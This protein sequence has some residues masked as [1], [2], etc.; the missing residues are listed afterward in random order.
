VNALQRIHGA[1][2]TGGVLVDT[3][4]VSARPPVQTSAGRVGSLDMSEWLE[5]VHA[6]DN[7]V[8]HSIEDGLWVHDDERR[9]VVGDTFESGTELVETVKGWQGTR[10]SDA[11]TR[12]LRA[13][14]GQAY[15]QQDVRLRVLRAL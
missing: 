4:P 15:V 6:V 8:A 11:L 10:I 14:E 1:L 13:A 2:V 9:F 7:H 12:R 5:L 3:Q